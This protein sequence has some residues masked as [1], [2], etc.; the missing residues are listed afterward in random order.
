M[1]EVSHRNQ[2]G[3]KN[4]GH[5]KKNQRKRDIFVLHRDL[6]HDRGNVEIYVVDRGKA[7]LY[8]SIACLAYELIEGVWNIYGL[9]TV[10]M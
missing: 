8:E 4:W 1:S 10:G 6:S 2:N 9:I 5:R 3:R 7:R